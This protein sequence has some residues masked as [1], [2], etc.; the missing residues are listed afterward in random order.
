MRWKRLYQILQPESSGTAA[1]LFRLVHHVMVG[2]GIAIMLAD[3]EVAWRDAYHVWLD[4]GF[5]LA[6]TFFI[7]EYVARLLAAPG[8]P[9]AHRRG[10][11]ARLAWALSPSGAFDL[12]GALPG[13]LDIAFSPRYASLYGFIWAFKA[14]RYAPGLVS[15][16]R[17]ISRA[18]GALLSVLLGFGIVLL[19]AASLAYLLERNAQPDKFGS[20]PQALWWAIVTLTTTGYGDVTPVTPLGR[21]LAGVV[22]ISGIMVFALWAGILATGYAEELRRREFLRTWDLVAKVP[23]F[24]KVGASVIADVARLLRPREYP[25]R[26]IIVRRGEHGDCMYFIAS[27]EVEVRLRPGT[28]RLGPGEFFGEIALLTGEPRNATIAAVQPCTL[29]TLDIVDFRQL[30]GHQPDLA[31]VV[32]EEAERRLQSHNPRRR[33][34]RAAAIEPDPAQ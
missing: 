20:I 17:V 25:A 32:S 9:G 1:R 6:C 21:I 15:L 12:L 2:L 10:W 4:P 22:M 19:A 29:L 31:R 24:D 23:F 3:T 33:P 16:Q 7:A 8:A 18:R 26:A 11:R 27:G 5:Q 28:I 14:V 30:L 13:I 34:P